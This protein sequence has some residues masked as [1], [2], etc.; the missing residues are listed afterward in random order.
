MMPNQL[1]EENS[2]SSESS[3][4]TFF[5]EIEELDPES[6]SS[7]EKWNLNW[8]NE[9]MSEKLQREETAYRS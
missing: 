6:L 1:E 8:T 9:K 7:G 2:E 4:P 3:E 5:V